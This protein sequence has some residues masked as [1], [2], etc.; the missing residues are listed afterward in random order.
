MAGKTYEQKLGIIEDSAIAEE[1]KTEYSRNQPTQEVA[2]NTDDLHDACKTSLD[3]LA[4]VAMPTVFRY[5]F[6][7]VYKAIWQ[8]LVSYVHRQRDFSQLALGLPRGFAKT[9]VIKLFV[10]YCI[11]F[12]DRRFILVISEN[13]TKA[14][15][16]LADICDMLSESNIRKIFGDW[17]IGVETDRQD[18]K[19]FGFRGRNVI[20]M[21]A[22]ADSGI[23]GIV[24]KNERPDIMIFDDIQ[25][26]EDAESEVISTQLETWMVGT[27]MKAKSPHGCLFIFIANMYPTKFSILRKLKRNPNWIKFIAGG[28]LENGTSLWEDLQPLEQLLKEYEND[29]LMGK[30]EV[31]RAEVLNDEEASVNHLIDISKIP[32]FDIQPNDIPAGTFI[33]IDPSNDKANSDAVSICYFEV[34]NSV[35]YCYEVQEGRF[36]P[37]RTIEIALELALRKNC[38]VIAIESNA[39]Q[40]SLNYWFTFI[41]AQRGIMG[42][43]AV[44]V[45]SGALSKVTRILNLFKALLAGEVGY[46]TNCAPA[47]HMQI[48]GFNPLRRDNT[49]GLLDCLAY[50]PRVAQEFAHLITASSIVEMQEYSKITVHSALENS[51]F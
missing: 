9:T 24:L 10:L 33:I 2:V 45:Y 1:V 26:R 44:E 25:S 15:N 51:C 22:G 28:I 29:L 23:R 3:V 18:L 40:Y 47:I 5:L 20:L 7:T 38:R 21:G 41:C 48:T 37:G 34:H 35:P 32:P 8:W 43:E 11:L 39:Y 14:N 42:I 31:F 17:R 49:D 50:A 13:Q 4:G 36:S 12:T 46:H 16:I 19:K 30:P 6:P 27:A